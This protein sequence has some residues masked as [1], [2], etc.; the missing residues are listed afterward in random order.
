MKSTEIV[1]KVDPFR[2][3]IRWGDFYAKKIIEYLGLV[4]QDGVTRVSLVHYNTEEEI[5]KLIEAF[6]QIL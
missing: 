4:K 3:G 2:I 5:D 6:E 1:E